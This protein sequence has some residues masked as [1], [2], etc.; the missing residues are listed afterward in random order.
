MS[1]ISDSGRNGECVKRKPQRLSECWG[2]N[3]PYCEGQNECNLLSIS[4]RTLKGKFDC[5]SE[6]LTH[7]KYIKRL[8]YLKEEN[9]RKNKGKTLQQTHSNT[10]LNEYQDAS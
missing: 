9:I 5:S 1:S 8:L 7:G 6:V 3:K 2:E 10:Q 4:K